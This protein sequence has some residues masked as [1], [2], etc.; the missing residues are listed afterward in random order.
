MKF[1]PKTEDQLAEESLLPEGVYPFDIINAVDTF[2]KAGNE[3]LKIKL[4]VY[5]N[6]GQTPHLYDYL[7]EKIAFK[8]RHFAETTGLLKEYERGELNAAM[9]SGK[10]GFCKLAIEPAGDY[11]AKNIVKDYVVQEANHPSASNAPKRA[12]PPP[13]A[14]K[15]PG[16]AGAAF[17]DD[18]PF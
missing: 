17:D 12:T 5:G 13:K 18:I 8:L 6:D 3:M 2:S 16:T 11:P 1:Q 7:L 10:C 4:M 15:A 9:C 14:S